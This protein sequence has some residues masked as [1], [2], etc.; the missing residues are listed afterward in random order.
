MGAQ[1]RRSCYRLSPAAGSMVYYCRV[2]IILLLAERAIFLVVAARSITSG[3]IIDTPQ[4]AAAPAP[5]HSNPASG[6]EVITGPQYACNFDEYPDLA[7]Y[8]FCDRSLPDF[9]RAQDL[10]ARLSLEEKLAELVNSAA[11]ITR[12][13]VPRYQWWNEALHGVASSPGVNYNG[14]IHAATSFPQPIL[15]AAAFN[16]TLWNQIG[17]VQIDRSIDHIW[18]ILHPPS[19]NVFWYLLMF[20]WWV[21][22][23]LWRVPAAFATPSEARWAIAIRKRIAKGLV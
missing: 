3:I 19:I 13:G 12:L 6:A 2:I 22:E 14:T 10:V 15:T 9:V 8:P 4:E 21:L 17:Q 16:L 20:W 7:S 11:N 18:V 23:H 5:D 1:A